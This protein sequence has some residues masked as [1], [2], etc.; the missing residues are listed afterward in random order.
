MRIFGWVKDGGVCLLLIGMTALF[1]YQRVNFSILPFED[2]AILMRYAKHVSE[3]RGIVWNPGEAP[4][5]GATDF[6]F[7]LLTGL[8]TKAGIPLERAVRSLGVLAHCATVALIYLAVRRLYAAN[9][10]CATLSALYLATG[11]G[12]Y[13]VAAYFGTPVFATA[14]CITWIVALAMMLDHSALPAK[15]RLFA[16]CALLM[17]L[18][19]PE[20]VFMAVFMLCAVVLFLGIPKSW[21]VLFWF[22]IVF[23]LLGGAYF[24][25]H[26]HYFGH[27]LPNPFYRKGGGLYLKSFRTSVENTIRLGLP[28]ILAFVLG[29]RTKQTLRMLV[30]FCIPVIGFTSI[31]ILLS[32][33]MNFGGRFQ[34]PILPL[35]LLSWY[36]LV[37]TLRADL[38]LP[39]FSQFDVGTK[40][41][42]AVTVALVIGGIFRYQIGKS[43]L[44]T[45]PRDGRYDVALLLSAYQD[46]GYTLATT[47]AGLLPLYSRWRT[48]DTWGLNDHWIARQGGITAED[49][50]QSAPQILMWHEDRW[51]RALST[52]E[53]DRAW[54][55]MID[56]LKAYAH[57]HHYVLAAA[58]GESPNKTHQYYV[59]SD[60]AD[61]REL[62]ERIR[63]LEY[64]WYGSGRASVNYALFQYNPE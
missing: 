27:P 16:L 11:P 57:E 25:W 3:G 5:D 54:W 44:I 50:D 7:M 28:W 32:D 41:A 59:A 34:Y 45:Y 15:A 21:T 53:R 40:L 4:V 56:T 9:V 37:K 24:V 13:L 38:R 52:T 36:P 48:V 26:W 64:A 18:I 23:A 12:L 51:Q 29:I 14:V 19:R 20:G 60:F 30:C 6:L 31:W 22:I 42:L 49:L 2:A 10:Y 62:I 1:A 17:G 47:E 63:S 35:I 43:S 58:F 39:R 46:K 33:E 61:S 8:L 55:A